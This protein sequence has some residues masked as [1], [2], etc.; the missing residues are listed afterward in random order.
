MAANEPIATT[1]IPGQEVLSSWLLIHKPSICL[2][3]DESASGNGVSS[4]YNY[5]DISFHI[6]PSNT[7]L[8]VEVSSVE[9]KTIYIQI[10][11]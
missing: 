7:T 1:P 5:F 3:I 8:W 10:V 4:P 2:E 9:V 6:D 11:S